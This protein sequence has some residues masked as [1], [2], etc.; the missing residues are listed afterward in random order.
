MTFL[1]LNCER[2]NTGIT[3]AMRED[4]FLILL[5]MKTCP[6][7]DLYAD[8]GLKRYNFALGHKRTTGRPSLIALNTSARL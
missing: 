1:E 5:Q 4:A 2:R 8:G 6:D 3:Q 7:F